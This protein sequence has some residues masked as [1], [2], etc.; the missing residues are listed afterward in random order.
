MKR[1][2]NK[3][4]KFR[5]GAASIYVVVFT[6]LL[7]GIIT[8]G[9]IRL[10]FSESSQ[11]SNTD[12]SQ[13]AYDSALAGIEDAK[14]A[15]LK[16]HECLSQGFKADKDGN[17]CQ[18]IIY[19]M[20]EGIKNGSCDTVSTTLFRQSEKDKSVVVQ[21]TQKS[22]DKGSAKNLEQAY[23]CVKI[24]EELP[25]Y[26]SSINSKNHTRIVP[27]RT[28]QK[29]NIR[30][31]DLKWFSTV[32]LGGKSTK[33]P[34]N[35]SLDPAPS[36]DPF[37]PPVISVQFFQASE[38]FRLQDFESSSTIGTNRGNLMLYP[39]QSGGTNYINQSSG[40]HKSNTK[41]Q[42]NNK[43][44]INCRPGDDFYCRATI[45]IPPTFNQ[46]AR[47]PGATFMIINLP[48]GQPNTDFSIT[49]C[50]NHGCNNSTNPNPPRFVGV[51]ALIDSTGRAND[52]YR[53]VES[54][55]ELVDIHYPYPDYSIQLQGGG[56]DSLVK[57]FWVTRN[58]QQSDNGSLSQCIN[59]SEL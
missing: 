6:T 52:L 40:L 7:L 19:N 30:F 27:I 16:Y 34:Y 12:L 25:D 38:N 3:L 47:H 41:A 45:E 20:S 4:N 29:D 46:A 23:T 26:R 43:F 39:V 14:I 44:E 10:M 15:L 58:C 49:P 35:K 48:Y 57:N 18:K 24:S 53:R 13:S 33:Y 50:N 59:N 5:S 1:N 42:T 32:N 9:F 56:E 2:K 11:S 22:T 31:L 54:R 51:Q 17:N 36:G 37:S 28:N 21:E 55:V 8:I